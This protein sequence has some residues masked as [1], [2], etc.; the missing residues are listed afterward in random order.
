[1][2]DDS[3]SNWVTI[4]V[5]LSTVFAVH[6]LT[7]IRDR[8]KVIYELHGKILEMAD[9]AAAD[10]VEAWSSECSQIRAVAVAA[11]RWRLQNLG[12]AL[13]RLEILSH[14]WRIRW[15]LYGPG[16][17]NVS[18]KTAAAMA[19]FRRDLMQDPFEDTL[20]P[21]NPLKATEC[22]SAKGRLVL[23]LDL[24]LRNWIVPF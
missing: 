18:I 16:M 6:R 20:R 14:Q 2:A 4:F 9:R 21:A 19:E 22:E 23:A 17:I 7:K 10:A 1:M 5:G 12:S 13:A 3:I 24:G 15:S 8:E 11:T